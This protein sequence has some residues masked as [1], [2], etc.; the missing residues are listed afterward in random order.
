MFEAIKTHIEMAEAEHAKLKGGN[1][2]AA[3]RCRSHLMLI[4]KECDKLRKECMEV[5]K[6]IP[7]KTKK[8]KVKEAPKE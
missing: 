2:S 8:A 1:K 3:T 5:K 7:K 4:K 6:S